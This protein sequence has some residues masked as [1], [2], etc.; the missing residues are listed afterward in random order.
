MIAD[1]GSTRPGDDTVA[2]PVK[3]KQPRVINVVSVVLVLLLAAGGWAGYEM[4]RVAFL[5]QEAFRVLEETGSTF[6][7]RRQLYRKDA[8]EREAL[9]GRMESQIRQIGV[10]DPELESWIEVEGTAANFGAVF[11]AEYHWPFDVLEPFRRDVQIEH[12]VTLPE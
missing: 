8:R 5:R 9:R 3:Y 7:G 10:D 1:G 2:E 12:L 11:T 4:I 6:A